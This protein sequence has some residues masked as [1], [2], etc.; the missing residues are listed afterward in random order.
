MNLSFGVQPDILVGWRSNDPPK[1]Q[2]HLLDQKLDDALHAFHDVRNLVVNDPFAANQV[3][4]EIDRLWPDY[5]PLWAGN[6]K[7]LLSHEAVTAV[8]VQGTERVAAFDPKPPV[9]K[10]SFWEAG[11]CYGNAAARSDPLRVRSASY[12]RSGDPGLDR[13]GGNARQVP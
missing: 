4:V 1:R 12:G 10:G 9:V 13:G 8:C 3:S 6:V 7:W 5:C 2:V 11:R